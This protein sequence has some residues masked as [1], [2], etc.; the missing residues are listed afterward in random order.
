[1][2]LSHGGCSSIIGVTG[3]RLLKKTTRVH[4]GVW[5]GGGGR[6]KSKQ[7]QTKNQKDGP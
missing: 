5:A 6:K 1:M 7:K 2:T 3:H 4:Y